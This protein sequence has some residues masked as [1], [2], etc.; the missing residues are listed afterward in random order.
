MSEHFFQVEGVVE[1]TYN[2]PLRTMLIHWHDLGPHDHTRPC[3]EAQLV[4]T[5]ANGAKAM[6]LETSQAKGVISKEDQQWFSDYLFPKF[7]EAGLEK[8]ITV[9]PEDAFARLAANYWQKLG[10][11]FGIEFF[12]TGS[13]AHAVQIVESDGDEAAVTSRTG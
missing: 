11:Q 13:L 1:A 6:I 3:C 8:I 12:E 10:K 5:N 7:E 4:F 9:V 2:A